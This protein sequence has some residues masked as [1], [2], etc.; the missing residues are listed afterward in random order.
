M[1]LSR[2]VKRSS[3]AGGG[4]EVLGF[5]FDFG[6]IDGFAGRRKKKTEMELEKGLMHVLLSSTYG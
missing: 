1:C 3:I 4:C 5:S 6:A 2:V